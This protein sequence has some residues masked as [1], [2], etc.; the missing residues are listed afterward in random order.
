MKK[1][2]Q[3]MVKE[4]KAHEKKAWHDKEWWDFEQLEST[5]DIL[6]AMNTC[7]KG[8]SLKEIAEEANK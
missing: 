3:K 4:V 5:R 1:I 6:Y 2:T 8:A 7:R